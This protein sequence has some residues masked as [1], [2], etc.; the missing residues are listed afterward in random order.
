L[1]IFG[2]SLVIR[3]EDGWQITDA[4]RALLAAIENSAAE[5]AVEGADQFSGGRSD[6]FKFGPATHGRSQAPWTARP[7]DER[8]VWATGIIKA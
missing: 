8:S 6:V 3:D 2:Q 5:P 7:S 1:D 4:G